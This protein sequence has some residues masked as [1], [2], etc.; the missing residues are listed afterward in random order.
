MKYTV[1]PYQ[2]EDIEFVQEYDFLHSMEIQ[3]RDDYDKTLIFTV[4]EQ[5]GEICAVADISCHKSWQDERKQVPHYMKFYICA[6]S[7][8]SELYQIS[9]DYAWMLLEKRMKEHEGS[10]C[11]LLVYCRMGNLEEI[12]KYLEAGFSFD[13]T[14]P[15][16]RYHMQNPGTANLPAPYQ[17]EELPKKRANIKRYID[18]YALANEGVAD[19]LEEYCFRSNDDSF[20]SYYVTD[21]QDILAGISLWDMEESGVTGNLFVHPSYRRKSFGDALL[22][23][24]LERIRIRGYDLATTSLVGADN[25]A[26]QLYLSFGYELESFI[27]QMVKMTVA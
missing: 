20:A 22:K 23:T 9:I 27:V 2:E 18:A 8:D 7:D 24:A 19:N 16:L 13:E 26:M 21:G 12:Q 17:I 6:R 3:Y 1:R 11:G 15:V 4:L 5:D 14:V 10:P 25:D